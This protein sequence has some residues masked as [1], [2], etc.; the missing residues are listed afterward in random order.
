[1][2]SLLLPL[3]DDCS[4]TRELALDCEMVGVG[5]EGKKD[6]LARVSLVHTTLQQLFVINSQL[7]PCIFG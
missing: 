3:S 2:V 7:F 1:V 6:A 5:Y 4:V